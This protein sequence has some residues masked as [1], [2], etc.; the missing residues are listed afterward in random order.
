MTALGRPGPE[1]VRL[2]QQIALKQ[3][4]GKTL[5]NLFLASFPKE[6]SLSNTLSISLPATASLLIIF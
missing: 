2:T 1:G 4:L 5:L 3:K 6:I